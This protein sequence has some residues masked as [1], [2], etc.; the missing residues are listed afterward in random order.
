MNHRWRADAS[1]FS[2]AAAREIVQVGAHMT[3]GH[4]DLG[5]GNRPGGRQAGDL[6]VIGRDRGIG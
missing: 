5:P 3:G 1:E 6:P 4:I 2:G